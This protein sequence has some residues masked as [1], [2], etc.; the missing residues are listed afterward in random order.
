MITPVLT[1]TGDLPHDFG[2]FVD[3]G[4]DGTA[5][6][7]AA[8]GFAGEEAGACNRGQVAAFA[9]FVRG[10]KALGRV[11]NDGNAVLGSNGVDGVKVC[12]LTVQT[13]RDDGFRAGC[14]GRFEQAWVQVVGARVNIDIDRLGSQQ[15]HGLCCSDVGKARG[16]DFVP[17]ANAQ[18]HLGNLQRI[19]AV[20]HSDAMLGAG[21]GGQLFFQLSHFGAKNVLAVVE[22]ALYASVNV[23]LKALVLGF[24]VDKVHG[25]SRLR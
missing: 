19:S 4:K 20:G 1:V 2:Q 23:S 8:Q 11:F 17:G 16:N 5:V 22:H 3:V 24:E 15:S 14:D 13:D 6:A 25:V 10:T 9:T 12:T 7:V 21:V 18:R